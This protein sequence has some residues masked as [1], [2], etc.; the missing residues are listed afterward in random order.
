MAGHATELAG[1][2]SRAQAR[3][4]IEPLR[5]SLID[6]KQSRAPGFACAK[7]WIIGLERLQQIPSRITG[8]CVPATDHCEVALDVLLLDELVGIEQGLAAVEDLIPAFDRAC[9]RKVDPPNFCR[10]FLAQRERDIQALYGLVS[11]HY[12]EPLPGTAT[13]HNPR[14]NQVCAADRTYLT[15]WKSLARNIDPAASPTTLADFE[16]LGDTVKEAR[17]AMR[18][19]DTRLS[20]S[21]GG[22]IFTV[23]VPKNVS[24]PLLQ[25]LSLVAISYAYLNQRRLLQLLRSHVLL[26]HHDLYALL[27]HAAPQLTSPAFGRSSAKPLQEGI[28]HRLPWL[29]TTALFDIIPYVACCIGVTSVILATCFGPK[30]SEEFSSVAVVLSAV[31]AVLQLI[32]TTAYFEAQRKIRIKFAAWVTAPPTP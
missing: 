30:G 7:T 17:L 16:R 14:G 9:L 19:S 5:Q 18:S 6:A 10:Y 3:A 13:K 29:I 20:A 32:V 8:N 12:R 31:A 23:L 4:S 26:A 22:G 21:P 27:P 1:S 25:Y 24:Y 2:S 28:V 11:S 15:S